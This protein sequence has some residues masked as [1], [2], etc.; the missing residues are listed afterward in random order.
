MIKC[1]KIKLA[2]DG[3]KFDFDNPDRAKVVRPSMLV[4]ERYIKRFNA[5]TP[6]HGQKLIEDKEATK[7]YNEDSKEAKIA[8]KAQKAIDL[9][10]QTDVLRLAIGGLSGNND[11]ATIAKELQEAKKIIAELQATKAVEA[12]KEPPAE[13]NG[14]EGEP[15]KKRIGRPPKV[16]TQS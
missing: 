7:K 11:S 9:A 15:E 16:E 14:T 12:P 2:E 4:E 1:K 6:G 5:G 10:A 8:R 13:T 3:G